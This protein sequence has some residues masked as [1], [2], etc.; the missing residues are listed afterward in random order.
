MRAAPETASVHAAMPAAGGVG[1]AVVL[2][3]APA[4][5]GRPAALLPWTG[6]T[7]V[8]R[9]VGQLAALGVGTT[10]VLARPDWRRAVQDAVGA[11]AEVRASAAVADDL[12]AI[13]AAARA[14][15][16]ALLVLYG[17]L[18][19]HTEALVGLAGPA[20]GTG[21]LAGGTRRRLA[22][23]VQTRRGTL[24]SAASPYHDVGRPNATFLGVLRVA[25]SDHEAAAAAAERLAVLT[26]EPSAAW[27]AELDRKSARWR[28]ALARG[29]GAGDDFG[30]PDADDFAA[31]PE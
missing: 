4:E 15:G 7:V 9:V 29:E 30:V 5:D 23:R 8:A 2:A 10:I 1:T 28:L 17:E 27:R 18:V 24:I 12:R 31:E 20:A 21:I 16:G 22:F 25:P 13:A 11:G 6:G 26:A 14:T 3:T 19:T